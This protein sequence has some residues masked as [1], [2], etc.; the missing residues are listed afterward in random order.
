LPVKAELEIELDPQPQEESAKKKSKKV[1]VNKPQ[2]YKG[3][4]ASL[5]FH[6]TDVSDR[7]FM[8]TLND[9]VPEPEDCMTLE[10]GVNLQSNGR[11]ITGPEFIRENRMTLGEYYVLCQ[12]NQGDK[13]RY[14]KTEEGQPKDVHV[15]DGDSQHIGEDMSIR[16]DFLA[17]NRPISGKLFKTRPKTGRKDS[18][19][20]T[21]NIDKIR[22][23]QNTIV[24][25]KVN[26]N[27][28]RSETSINTNLRRNSSKPELQISRIKRSNP[29]LKAISKKRGVRPQTAKNYYTENI[30]KIRKEIDSRRTTL[31]KGMENKPIKEAVI[32][33]NEVKVQEYADSRSNFHTGYNIIEPEGANVLNASKSARGLRP[34]SAFKSKAP[35][36]PQHAISAF[37]KF[38]RE[39]LDHKVANESVKRLQ[40]KSAL[41][42]QKRIQSARRK[43]ASPAATGTLARQ[44]VGSAKMLKSSTPL[45]ANGINV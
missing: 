35:I 31:M 26:F 12:T 18:S 23:L 32:Q 42:N 25:K 37:D 38:N 33:Y 24:E 19:K 36:V 6:K 11:I 39:I 1:K 14:D 30:Q 40:P 13:I 9:R 20:I 10:P 45:K 28:F 5:I 22:L 29:A 17:P 3:I 16:Q 43:N 8:G 21:G 7:E 4:D 15:A 34:A 27:S 44:R 41:L 2:E